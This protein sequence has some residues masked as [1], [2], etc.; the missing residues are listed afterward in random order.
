MIER[1]R[2]TVLLEAV[3]FFDEVQ[4]KCSIRWPVSVWMCLQ[5]MHFSFKV[6]YLKI[7]L[8]SEERK[9]K[10]RKQVLV[11]SSFDYLTLLL[12]FLEHILLRS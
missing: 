6:M 11:M 1:R 10:K 9:S 8:M 12:L 4:V 2:E 3:I 7:K 5:A